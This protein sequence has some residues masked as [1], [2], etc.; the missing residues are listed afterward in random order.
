MINNLQ[1][2]NFL[3]RLSG[4]SY[5]TEKSTIAFYPTMSVRKATVVTKTADYT[6]TVTDLNKPTIFNNSG[7]SNNMVVTLPSVA[8]AKGKVLRLHALAAQTMQVLPQTGEI[9]NYNGSV[10]V[11]KYCQLAGTIGNYIELFCDGYQWVVTQANG[12]VTKEA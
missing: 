4:G 7:D 10:V 11:T 9:V 3:S 2:K 6:V 8:S 1:V 12:V 5:I